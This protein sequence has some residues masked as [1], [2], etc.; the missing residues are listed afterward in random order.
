M[1]FRTAGRG[2]TAGGAARPHGG[3]RWTWIPRAGYAVAALWFVLHLTGVGGWGFQ[4]TG[5]RLYAPVLAAI[6]AWLCWRAA[7]RTHLTGAR[8]YAVL[9]ALAWTVTAATGGW[10]LAWML[11]TGS[12]A[13]PSPSPAV[14]LGDLTAML[15]VLAGLLTVPIRTRWS[16]SSA[17]LA[18]DVAIVQVAG[19]LFAW[20]FLIHPRM[21]GHGGFVPALVLIKT[22]GLLVV[23]F[24][25]A[26]L[27]LGGPVEV[28]R[29]SL[30][31]SGLAAC[32]S[33]VVSICQRLLGEGS[34]HWTLAVWALFTAL[35]IAAGAAQMRAVAGAEV[36]EQAVAQ[37]PSS[38]VPYLAIAAA[39]ALLI[40]ALLG[41]LSARSWPVVG[42][43]IL[44]TGLVVV[45]Q[46]IGLRDNNR[47]LV[48]VDASVRALRQAVAREQILNDLGTSLLTT[49]DPAQVQRLAAAAAAAL[50]APCPG[51]RT[52]VVSVTPEDPDNWTV[53]HAAGNGAETVA[54]FRLPGEAVPAPLLTRLSNGEVISG[55]TLATLGVTGLDAVGERP[56]ML[57]PLLNGARFFGILLVGAE[58]E[59]PADVV[60]A[61]QTL[62]T[63]VSLAL[64]SVA[65]TAELTRRAMHDMLT[66]LGNRAL[67]WDRLTASLARARR[68]DRRIGVLLL[69]LNGFKPVNDTY[70]HDTGD[71]V[72]RIVADRL[73][74]CVRTEDT[75][76]RLG[77]DE[78][79]ILAEDLT[80]VAGALVIADR[81]V[82]AL[83]EPMVVDGHA[84]RTPASI[85][86][87]L[88]RPGQGAD[89]VLRDADAA[90]YVA[91]R[92]GT[93]R[94]HVH[95]DSDA[96][97]TTA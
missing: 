17:R 33:V 23:L 58:R 93:G 95:V 45:R 44:L 89:D 83:N 60:K 94:Y 11:V 39:C 27:V 34:Q 32:C 28:S 81:V 37:R 86:I 9:T 63:Q 19:M 70:G 21:L 66:G 75:V 67:L 51:A 42:G 6:P 77:G 82:R 10:A 29:R 14:P 36:A 16:A 97:T 61:L 87:A 79:V 88:S 22:C 71:E 55:T 25:I 26:R 1:Q 96:E 68:A 76:A 13:Y 53:L 18:M 3:G 31:W 84:L 43:S 52:V 38:L 91:K 41:G 64:D 85:G 20:Y 69:D 92:G 46:V 80:E 15:L 49:N 7:R 90:M 72:L 35:I 59:L 78:F 30:L 48:R 56:I 57:L 40:G 73:R 62:R 54:G 74:T 5:Y 4:L 8:R 47:L 50:V 2:L 65:L 12:L 24:A